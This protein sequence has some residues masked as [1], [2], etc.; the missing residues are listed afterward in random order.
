MNTYVYEFINDDD[1]PCQDLLEID[2]N[3]NDVNKNYT[4]DNKAKKFN[5]DAWDQKDTIF[6]EDYNNFNLLKTQVKINKKEESIFGNY[7]QSANVKSKQNTDRSISKSDSMEK[8]NNNHN[9]T[10]RKKVGE[11]PTAL[12]EG[13]F[14]FD[15]SYSKMDSPRLRN[16]YKKS[17]IG[18]ENSMDKDTDNVRYRSPYIGLYN[19]NNLLENSGGN[20]KRSD[21]VTYDSSLANQLSRIQPNIHKRKIISYGTMNPDPKKVSVEATINFTATNL[22]MNN[23]I[24]QKINP[25]NKASFQRLAKENAI[26]NENDKNIKQ[27]QKF[28]KHP[29]NYE[30]PKRPVNEE[31][32]DL[33]FDVR[34]KKQ[35]QNFQKS[36]NEEKKDILFDGRNIKQAYT[37]QKPVNEEKKD[38]LIDGKNRNKTQVFLN[39]HLNYEIP[40]KPLNEKKEI[41]FDGAISNKPYNILNNSNMSI[42]KTNEKLH[43]NLRANQ[44]HYTKD[45][46]SSVKINRDTDLSYDLNITKKITPKN[47]IKV[48][49]NDFLDVNII[50]TKKVTSTPEKAMKITR[51]EFL[52]KT[53]E[54]DLNK[55]F[56]DN[57]NHFLRVKNE[58]EDHYNH[59]WYQKK[60]RVKKV[61]NPRDYIKTDSF[62]MNIDE[63]GTKNLNKYDFRQKRNLF[64]NVDENS[65]TNDSFLNLTGKRTTQNDPIKCKIDFL[66]KYKKNF[67]ETFENKSFKTPNNRKNFK[68]H[69]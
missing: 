53:K 44:S 68:T 24:F 14:L 16:L 19:K 11:Y 52:L 23:K 61:N 69:T 64:I 15:P 55:K 21:D 6:T 47:N 29:I 58:T 32:K 39:H 5:V 17:I 59:N 13:E 33:I 43:N 30:I 45:Q 1:Q 54:L 66:N 2:S 56:E 62:Q 8:L 7:K 41:I 3:V 67:I 10:I 31:K 4:G 25:I 51:H 40:K 18:S 65:C 34:N 38:I 60:K 63:F 20:I 46:S 28:L 35:T 27:T 22:C 49:K 36:I 42:I 37:F 9:S 57:I 26:K 48:I 12:Y 50:G